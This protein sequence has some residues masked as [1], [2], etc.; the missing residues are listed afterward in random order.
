L[1]GPSPQRDLL[2]DLQ[3]SL[4]AFYALDPQAPV[5]DF[6]IPANEAAAYPGGGSR[7]LVREEAG[8]IRLG[9]VFDET[10]ARRLRESDPRVRL[11]SGNLDPFATATEEVS[12]FVYLT[13][14]AGSE[15]SI[16]QLELELQAEVDKYLT[17]RSYLSLQNDG[18]VARGLRQ[19]LFRRYRLPEGLTPERAERY[20]AASRLADRYCG[21]LEACFLRPGRFADLAREARRFYRL[22]QGEKL[23]R[24]DRI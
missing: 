17:T 20:H 15:R 11:D 16:T 8:E 2:I 12:H 10:T 23:V 1:I 14:C 22:G 13:F 6:V 21:W 9:V 24:I 3:R 4:E 18:T 5:T 7:T 19:M